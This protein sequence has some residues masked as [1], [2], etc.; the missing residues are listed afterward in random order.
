MFAVERGRMARVTTAEVADIMDSDPD[1]QANSLE[2]GVE[3]ANLV[4]NEDLVPTGKLSE[5]RLRLVELWLAAHYASTENP[6]VE[7]HESG[8][9]STD[10]EAATGEGYAETRYGRRALE[11]DSTGALA[12]AHK[13]EAVFETFGV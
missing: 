11:L 2:R 4:V 6:S 1:P 3:A 13:S 10:Y 5:A 12:D 9:S 7:S 8:D